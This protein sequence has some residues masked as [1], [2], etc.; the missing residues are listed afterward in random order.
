MRPGHQATLEKG[1]QNQLNMKFGSM[2]PS[3]ANPTW[4]HHAQLASI[5]LLADGSQHGLLLSTPKR[6]A[7]AVAVPDSPHRAWVTLRVSQVPQRV[8]LLLQS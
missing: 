4:L 7:N 5:H 6:S 3:V 8:G 2:K 1:A